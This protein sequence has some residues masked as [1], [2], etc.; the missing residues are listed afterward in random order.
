MRLLIAAAALMLSGCG[1]NLDTLP[2]AYQGEW[3]I[4][5]ALCGDEDGVSRLTIGPRLLGYYD[6]FAKLAGPI[7]R[8]K[9]RVSA[10]F[11][12]GGA[13]YLDGPPP[14]KGVQIDLTLGGYGNRLTVAL[15]GGSEEYVR[16]PR[17]VA[18]T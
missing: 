13:N 14:P 3:D 11:D 16:C 18:Q 1:Q 2:D 5:A 17:P 12:L 4:S 10:R 8:D 6:D 7:Q 9:D 15:K